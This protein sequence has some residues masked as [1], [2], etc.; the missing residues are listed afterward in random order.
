M[1]ISKESLEE[2]TCEAVCDT[3]EGMAFLELMRDSQVPEDARSQGDLLWASIE[4]KE[5]FLGK[6]DIVCPRSL[7]SAVAEA[8]YGEGAETLSKEKILDLLGEVANTVAGRLMNSIVSQESTFLLGL[9][10]TGQGWPATDGSEIFSF[11][12]DEEQRLFVALFMESPV[13]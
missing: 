13:I 2:A 11:V 7:A 5:P 12:T 4:L 3:L 9:P 8:V 1:E 10:K 6:L